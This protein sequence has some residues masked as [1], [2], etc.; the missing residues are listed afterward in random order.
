[1]IFYHVIFF[2]FD[3][4]PLCSS[5][6]PVEFLYCT[7]LHSY[8]ISVLYS[9]SLSLSYQTCLNI[10]KGTAKAIQYLHTIQPCCHRW[11]SSKVHHRNDIFKNSVYYAYM[12]AEQQELAW[13][14][15][16]LE[17][18][19][20]KALLNS[21]KTFSNILVKIISWV[22]SSCLLLLRVP[23]SLKG[24]EVTWGCTG[25]PHFSSARGHGMNLWVGVVH[26]HKIHCKIRGWI[27]QFHPWLKLSGYFELYEYKN[28]ARV[29]DNHFCITSVFFTEYESR[30]IVFTWTN[31]QIFL[32]IH[33]FT[34]LLCMRPSTW[35][36]ISRRNMILEVA[37]NWRENLEW[38]YL[39]H[40]YINN[41]LL[42]TDTE[43]CCSEPLT[44]CMLILSTCPNW[45]K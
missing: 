19:C 3:H 6:L 39:L 41:T 4:L 38:N 35:N 23:S 11:Q 15:M 25:G 10:L 1:M 13:H 26:L 43:Q 33:L 5:I 31:I 7:K 17:S 21:I 12:V 44:Q 16:Y 37:S 22:L 42:L 29:H 14:G 2:F 40:V 45:K 28:W 18:N 8:S 34:Y 36:L 32:F 24:T 30:R 9:G 27:F 20:F